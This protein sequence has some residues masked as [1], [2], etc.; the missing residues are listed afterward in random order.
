MTDLVLE[1][2]GI[3]SMEEL[4]TVDEIMAFLKISRDTLYRYMRDGIIPFVQ[5]GGQRRFIGTQVSKAIKDL[6][7]R[8]H[9]N[10]LRNVRMDA[11]E[12]VSMSV[13]NDTLSDVKHKASHRKK[14][15]HRKLR[16]LD[17]PQDNL[18]KNPNNH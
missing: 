1:E 9:V 3:K 12:K 15:S 5:I 6:Q 8:Q 14:R 17:L 11:P 10:G 4:Y 13:R 2:G 18:S 16:P 7:K